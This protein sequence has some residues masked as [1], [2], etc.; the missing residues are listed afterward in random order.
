MKKT[1]QK[2]NAITLIALV[3][4]II[5]LLLL[6][7]ISITMLTGQNGILNRA[8]EAKEKNDAA[9]NDENNKL[10]NYENIMNMYESGDNYVPIEDISDEIDGL[11]EKKTAEQLAGYIPIYTKEQFAKIASGETCAI[12]DLSGNSKGS[13]TMAVDAKYALMNDLDFQSASTTK[14]IKN[15]K[16]EFEGNGCVISNLNIDTTGDTSYTNPGGYT[17]TEVPAALFECV[18][19]GKISN[20]AV[21]DSV[22]KGKES[23]AAIAGQGDNVTIENCY[24]KNN[25]FSL[26]N[27][28]YTGSSGGIIGYVWHNGATI[29]NCKV[30]YSILKDDISKKI[31]GICGASCGDIAINNCKVL[32]DMSEE[33]T[34]SSGIIDC[35]GANIDINNCSVQNINVIYAGI[36]GKA[37][38]T[39]DQSYS[40]TVT[41]NLNISNCSAKG[42]KTRSSGIVALAVKDSGSINGCRVENV[43]FDDPDVDTTSG[44]FSTMGGIVSITFTLINIENC[45]VREINVVNGGQFGGIVGAHPDSSKEMGEKLTIK[46]CNVTNV[47]LENIKSFGGMIAIT[48]KR[49]EVEQC[50]SSKI[51]GSCKI[52]FGGIIGNGEIQY[53]TTKPIEVK[54]CSVNNINVTATDSIGGIVGYGRLMQIEECIVSD[55]ELIQNT[56]EIYR[57]N[58]GIVGFLSNGTI[59]NCA[60]KNV[61]LKNNSGVVGGILG[62]DDTTSVE[63]CNVYGGSIISTSSMHG[64]GGIC[65]LG[66]NVSNCTV[67]GL[68]IEAPNTMG[69]AGIVGHGKNNISTSL[70]Q[71]CSIKNCQIKGK[72]YVGG[73]AGAA[74]INIS[75]CQVEGSTI[76]GTD[77]VGGIQGFGGEFESTTSY[78]PIKIDKGE[79]TN[80]EIKGTTN[81]N[82]IQGCNTYIKD[83][84]DPTKDTITNCKYNGNS[85]TQ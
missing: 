22:F 61:N 17:T 37:T 59:A 69:V 4:T 73:I 62:G 30:I 58:G 26:N 24:S 48:C 65:G 66:T 13:Y 70:I 72:D 3:V 6:A 14:P 19:N 54:K 8:G 71:N 75:N 76:E 28:S 32:G 52:W 80:T 77:S 57:D 23:I 27:S 35:A 38:K 7:G 2:Q 40:D 60:T 10:T 68:K 53:K 44:T 81:V 45:S 34:F 39:L 25:S 83:S 78:V 33:N 5:V 67:E 16:G 11:P 41:Y 47:K 51:E 12:T 56:T 18:V 29:N 84:T 43:T 63:N 82:N 31:G 46:N 55:S 42:I 74:F 36:L 85:V 20:L 15:F 21:I 1:L 50:T 9:Q 64:A 79:V 49:I